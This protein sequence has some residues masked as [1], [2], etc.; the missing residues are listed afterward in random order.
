[1]PRILSSIT[2]AAA[3][4]TLSC[5]GEMSNLVPHATNEVIIME[6]EQEIGYVQSLILQDPPLFSTE[7]QFQKIKMY[8][9][10]HYGKVFVLDDCL[11]LTEKDAPHYNE[12]LAHVAMMEYIAKK[13]V[14]KSEDND[15]KLRVLVIGGGDGYVVSEVLKHP[16]VAFVDHVELDDAV[17]QSSAKLFPWA[18]NVWDHPK[19]NLHIADGAQ[20]V[21]ERLSQNHSYHVIIQDASDPF[22]YDKDDN[23]VILPSHVLYTRE[24][25]ETMHALLRPNNGVMVMQAETYNIPSNL[26]EIRKWLQELRSIGFGKNRYGGISIG[27]YPT[28]Q[29]G[30]IVSHAGEGEDGD[31]SDMV[32][33]SELCE[34]DNNQGLGMAEYSKIEEYFK[35]LP[36]TTK[37]YHP[38][39]HRSSFDLP[40]WVERSIYS[41]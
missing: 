16:S 38:R 8:E 15:N 34:D 41:N 18:A 5:H 25:F 19:V 40:L 14:K 36:P 21:K 7:S 39:I 9:S 10:K 28:G 32:C 12:M 6:D 17:I 26:I 37:Y 20:F 4:L 29:I 1:M 3:F 30:F 11:Q 31:E 27:T 22:Y 35:T 33:Q 24:H 2:C 13:D 23:I